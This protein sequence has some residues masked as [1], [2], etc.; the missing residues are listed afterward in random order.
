MF[1]LLHP[2]DRPWPLSQ[3]TDV[4]RGGSGGE[5]LVPEFKAKVS[6]SSPEPC[7]QA[8]RPSQHRETAKAKVV[9]T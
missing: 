2:H 7:P 8:L 5:W 9:P 6:D 3:I 1:A 4:T